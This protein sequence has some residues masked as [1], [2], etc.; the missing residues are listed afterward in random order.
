MECVLLSEGFSS[1]GALAASSGVEGEGDAR[2]VM[3][4]FWH[5]DS[6]ILIRTMNKKRIKS[7]SSIRVNR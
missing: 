3:A 2:S 5:A 1:D 6:V 7:D 4:K